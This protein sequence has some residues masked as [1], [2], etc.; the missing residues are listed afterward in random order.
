M[1]SK[2]EKQCMQLFANLLNVR[3][4]KSGSGCEMEQNTLLCIQK[5]IPF[6]Y[7]IIYSD[8]LTNTYLMVTSILTSDLLLNLTLTKVSECLSCCQGSKPESRV[9]QWHH[10]EV[11]SPRLTPGTVHLNMGKNT[12]SFLVIC[13]FTESVLVNVWILHPGL[14]AIN[15]LSIKSIVLFIMLTLETSYELWWNQYSIAGYLELE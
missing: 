13:C 4:G 10:R 11:S 6:L 2:V 12:F 5:A 9:P 8:I 1:N 15:K 14:A 3:Y 7:N